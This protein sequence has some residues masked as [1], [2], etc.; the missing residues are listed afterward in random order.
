MEVVLPQK[1]LQE[2]QKEVYKLGKPVHLKED[3][4]QLQQ[5]WIQANLKHL[6]IT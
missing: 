2:H 1:T 4:I 3:I 5:L 6:I